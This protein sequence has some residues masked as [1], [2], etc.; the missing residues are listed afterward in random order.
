MLWYTFEKVSFVPSLHFILFLSDDVKQTQAPAGEN[1]TTI[2]EAKLRALRT[3]HWRL[4]SSRKSAATKTNKKELLDDL[5]LHL[6]GQAF[7][8][9]KSQVLMSDVKGRGRR[10]ARR[11]KS[12][13][14]TLFHKSPKIYKLLRKVFFLPSVTTLRRSLKG[15]KLNPG[16]NKNLFK[17]LQL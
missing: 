16:F 3:T 5:S 14:L 12:F 17:A 6:S 11:D 15:F 9:I 7:S 1:R 13:A 2:L 8:F 10:W 4:K